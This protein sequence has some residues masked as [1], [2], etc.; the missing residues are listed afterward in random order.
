[1]PAHKWLSYLGPSLVK[2]DLC[3][4]SLFTDG[5]S[6]PGTVSSAAIP[7]TLLEEWR[8]KMKVCVTNSVLTML[9]SLIPTY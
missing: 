1:M 5:P 9:A 6:C 7:I 3:P 2:P 8:I 4:V